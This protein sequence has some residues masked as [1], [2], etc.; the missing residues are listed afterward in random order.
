MKGVKVPKVGGVDGVLGALGNV[1]SLS[2]D[3]EA[4]GRVHADAARLCKSGK[5]KRGT[6]KGAPG[7]S[8][9]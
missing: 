2:G 5:G 9:Q 8:W 1:C 4:L 3:A 7:K 6:H